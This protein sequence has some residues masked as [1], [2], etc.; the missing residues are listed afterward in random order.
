MMQHIILQSVVTRPTIIRSIIEIMIH[1]SIRSTIETMTR[2]SIRYVIET[3]FYFKRYIHL[4]Y[5]RLVIALARSH[6]WLPDGQCNDNNNKCHNN[7]AS[8]SSSDSND[9]V[10]M[11]ALVTEQQIWRVATGSNKN[12]VATKILHR[13]ICTNWLCRTVP[14]VDV[15]SLALWTRLLGLHFTFTFVVLSTTISFTCFTVYACTQ[16]LGI[17]LHQSTSMVGICRHF[18]SPHSSHCIIS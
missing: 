15:N 12:A 5:L 11:H 13:S 10:L 16:C 6:R 17:S 4:L 7:G 18:I 14:H 8:D 9:Y 2:W 1:W 3:I